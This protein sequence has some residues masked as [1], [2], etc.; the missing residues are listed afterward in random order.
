MYFLQ[1][2]YYMK[3]L[4]KV[5][6]PFLKICCYYVMFL[7][8]RVIFSL[9]PYRMVYVSLFLEGFHKYMGGSVL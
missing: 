6:L 5:C 8:L 4:S 1:C 7:T 2:N 3:L 9:F